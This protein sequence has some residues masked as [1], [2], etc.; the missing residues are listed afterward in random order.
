MTAMPAPKDPKLAGAD[1]DRHPHGRHLWR[2]QVLHRHRRGDHLP[3]L[4]ELSDVLRSSRDYDAQLDAWQGW[5]TISQPMRKD[6]SASPN[7]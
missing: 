4:G 3:R 7:W 2:G 6:Y 1:P 5:H